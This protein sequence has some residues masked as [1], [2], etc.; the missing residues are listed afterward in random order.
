[1]AKVSQKVINDIVKRINPVT[2]VPLAQSGTLQFE[3]MNALL[4]SNASSHEEGQLSC[5]VDDMSFFTRNY[6]ESPE[7]KVFNSVIRCAVCDDFEIGINAHELAD[8]YQIP[9]AKVLA[10]LIDDGQLNAEQA[11]FFTRAL[12]KTDRALKGGSGTVIS[13]SS[14]KYRANKALTEAQL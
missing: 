11:V 2:G 3:V 8:D 14:Y 12:Q 10:Y 6:D 7:S 4:R 13:F 9:F 1:M 5:L